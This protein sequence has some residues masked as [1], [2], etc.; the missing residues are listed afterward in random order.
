MFAGLISFN[1]KFLPKQHFS[2]ED[3]RTSLSPYRVPD[4]VGF[5]QSD[6][7]CLLEIRTHI[8]SRNRDA[9]LPLRCQET[10]VVL[11]FWGRID[12]R[13]EL[14]DKL[15]L[16]VHSLARHTDAQLVLEGWRTWQESLPEHLI[17][18]FAIAVIDPRRNYAFLARDP[19]GVKPLYYRL[20]ANVFAFASSAAALKTLKNLPLTPD[21]E[22]MACYLWFLSMSHDKTA[23]SEIYKLPPGHTLTVDQYGNQQLKK[24]HHWRDDAPWADKRDE[25]WVNEYR[26]V[27]EE[28]IRCRMESDYPLGTENSGGLD[29][30]TV[31]AYLAHFMGCTPGDKLHT[32]GY[33]LC[34][35]EPGYILET[36]QAKG[37]V[38]NYLI[39][40]R[41]NADPLGSIARRLNALGYPEEHNMAAYHIPFYAEC[42]RRNVRT[43]FSGFGGD[44]VVSNRGH[45]LR[46]ELL[47]KNKYNLLW[48]LLPGNTFKRSLH[49]LKAISFGY[50]NLGYR[51]AFY[52][53]WKTRWPY[54]ILRDDVVEKYNIYHR[55]METAR[56]DAPYRS[57]NDFILQHL[58]KLP[59]IPV[60][61]ENCSLMAASYGI[62]YCWPL[63][64]ARLVQ[65]YLSTPSIEKAGP[66]GVK[67]YL[68][69]KAIDGIVPERVAWKKTKDMGNSLY[70]RLAQKTVTNKLALMAQKLGDEIHPALKELID[71]NRFDQQ[72]VVAINEHNSGEFLYAL[73]FNLVSLFLLNNWLNSNS[74]KS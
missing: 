70:F 15:G 1:N 66:K 41:N 71:Y 9:V 6:A 32:F 18:D 39:T 72:I 62:E 35:Q 20:D 3:V 8:S 4:N 13:K 52:K 33:A 53:A 49:L 69:R 7:A 55:Y 11:A 5:W 61:L 28:A 2:P 47:D 27:L 63:L 50:P 40:S 56:Y 74:I 10:G 21:Q 58:L 14:A 67:R 37:I 19:V 25:R 42:E 26:E 30:A 22:W 46:F 38:H 16:D 73:R 64:D 48:E 24:W 65:K 34:E 54:R 12:N 51:P 36:S 57:I 23:Y 17:G 29:S 68:H 31:T 44:E 45:L 59:Y 43:L 60:R